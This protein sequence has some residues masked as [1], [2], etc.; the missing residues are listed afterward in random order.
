M[1]KLL[2]LLGFFSRKGKSV[3]LHPEERELVKSELALRFLGGFELFSGN[4]D[5]VIGGSVLCCCLCM[6]VGLWGL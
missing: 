2:S 5:Y 1:V 6:Y 3:L 4:T